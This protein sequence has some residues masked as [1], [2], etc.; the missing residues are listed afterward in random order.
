ME[1]FELASEL[2]KKLKEDAR[3]VALE[4][5]KNAYEACTELKTYLTEYDVQQIAMQKA[6][7]QP[8]RDMQLIESIQR[9]IDELYTLISEHPLFAELNRTQEVV[10]ELMNKVNQTIMTQIT[11]EEPSGCTHNCSTCGGC[12]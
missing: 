4:E 10:N 5:A 1:I 8:E 11:G 3:L 7:T 2:G 12:H 6:V 9:R